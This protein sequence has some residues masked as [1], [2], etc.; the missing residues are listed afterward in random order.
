MH[1]LKL[2]QLTK[3]AHCA[4]THEA[5]TK[6]ITRKEK[7]SRHTKKIHDEALVHRG[8][9]FVH[10]SC[11]LWNPLD[12]GKCFLGDLHPRPYVRHLPRVSN[13]ITTSVHAVRVHNDFHVLRRQTCMKQYATASLGRCCVI[14]LR[15]PSPASSTVSFLMPSGPYPKRTLHFR[16]HIKG[17]NTGIDS[18]E[19]GI[20]TR[21]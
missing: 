14:S 6:D 15:S 4:Y 17:M 5:V 20:I 11:S 1:D 7:N 19:R 16:S 18:T 8:F 2:P 10:D 9:G 3:N 12:E 13:H 21:M